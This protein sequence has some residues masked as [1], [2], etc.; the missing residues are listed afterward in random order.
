MSGPTSGGAEPHF[1]QKALDNQWLMLALTILV[2]L[3]LYTI[4]GL[5]DVINIPTAP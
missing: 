1:M 3:V 4:W 2:P 5:Y